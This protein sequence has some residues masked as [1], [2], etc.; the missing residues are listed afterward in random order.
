MPAPIAK[1]TTFTLQIT[2]GGKLAEAA[3][4]KYESQNLAIATDFFSSAR[5]SR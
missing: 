1:R 2:N 3:K 4:V 5:H